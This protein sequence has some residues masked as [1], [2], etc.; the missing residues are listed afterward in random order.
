MLYFMNK[1]FGDSGT[2]NIPKTCPAQLHL[3]GSNKFRVRATFENYG[4]QDS[5][6]NSLGIG[7]HDSVIHQDDN[8]CIYR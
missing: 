6:F 4:G 7:N 2:L 5:Y 1:S 3:K 8:G